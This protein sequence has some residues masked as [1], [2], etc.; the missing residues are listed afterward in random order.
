MAC[1]HQVLGLRTFLSHAVTSSPSPMPANSNTLQIM[2]FPQFN[3]Q[4][5]EMFLRRRHQGV[6]MPSVR[7]H[8]QWMRS[9]IFHFCHKL[10]YFQPI[11]HHQIR[12]D[13][14]IQ[15]M[16]YKYIAYRNKKTYLC[17]STF[18]YFEQTAFYFTFF[19]IFHYILNFT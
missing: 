14:A 8:I 5:I 4:Q 12:T 3:L 19:S 17:H 10:P 18:L 7:Q 15:W 6:I 13:L 2:F 9:T 11:M 1:S 16:F